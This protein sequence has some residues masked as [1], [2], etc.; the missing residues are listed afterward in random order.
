MKTAFCILFA[1]AAML[2]AGFLSAAEQPVRIAVTKDNSIVM[3]DKEWRDNAGGAPRIRIKGNQHI[4]AMMFDAAAL[5]GRIVRSAVL[6]CQKGDAAI[7]GVTLSTIQA[8]WD[9]HKSNSITSGMPLAE[10]GLQATRGTPAE[11][12]GYPGARFPAVTGGNAFSL[13]CQGRSDSK[14]GAYRWQVEPDLVHAVAIGAA[15]GLSVHEWSAD[16]G[17]NPTVFSREQS[18]KAPYLEIV[19]GDAAAEPAPLPPTEL[20]LAAIDANDPAGLRLTLRGP[21]SGFAYEVAVDG[22]PLPRW[23]IPFV[24]PGEVQVIPIRD[25]RCDPRKPVTVQVTTLNRAGRRSETVSAT[26][27]ALSLKA[28]PMPEVLPPP[29]AGPPPEGLAVIPPEDRY[30]AAGRPV[31]DLPDDY[32][33]RNGV[34]DGRTVRLAAARGEVVGFQVLLKCGVRSAERGVEGKNGKVTIKCDLPGLRTDV[35]RAVYVQAEGGRR[36]PDPLIAVG[37]GEEMALSAAEAQPIV[38]D[39]FVP[40]DF[41]AG[42]VQGTLEVSDGRKLPIRLLVRPFAIPR[43]VSFAC[44]MNGYGLP[45]RVSQFYRIQEIAYDHRAHANIL[46]YSHSSTAPRSRKANMDMLMDGPAGDGSRRMDEKKYND[47]SPGA[48]RGHWEDFVAA[49]GPYLSGSFFARGHRGPVQPPGFYLTFHESWPL[50]VREFFDGSPDAYAAFRAK[51]A[52]AETFVNILRDFIATAAREGW[53]KT[54]FQVYLN[55][56]GRLGD[57]SRAPW[58]LDEPVSYWDYRALAYYGDLVRQARGAACPATVRCRIDISRPQ[59]DRGELWGKADLWVCATGSFHEFPRLV[60]DRAERTG[61]V[62]WIYGSTCKVEESARAVEAWVLDAWRGGARGVVPWQTIDRDGSAMMKADQLGLFIF[63]K[64][65]GGQPVIRHSMRLAAYR[66]AE[67]TVEYLEL[68]QRNL[69]LTPGQMRAFIDHYLNLAGTVATAYAEDA[70][71][72][73]YRKATPESLRQLREAAAM[74]LAK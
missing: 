4:V 46:S 40:F 2:A 11:G 23:N 39:V 51:P 45:D 8:D 30:D 21:K 58:T 25:V 12:W 69:N 34:F 6:V 1:S 13:V 20:K 22:E 50:R 19:F 33:W 52:Y 32:P 35:Y 41:K 59:Y 28:P 24:R 37:Q 66:S 67:Q 74:L 72:P 49:F 10:H 70:G 62:I 68:V 36:I 63:E 73:Q 47:I 43:E 5:R 57:P 9:E 14:D 56:K 26:G 64:Q 53:T 3:V 29:S 7:D 61:E 15:Y 65:P 17:R 27:P 16:Y 48:V 38:V 18:G 42:E 71:T 31:G 44:E 60:A 55:N 54:G